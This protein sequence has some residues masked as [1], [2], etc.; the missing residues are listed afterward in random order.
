MRAARRT[1]SALLAFLLL[2]PVIALTS[3]T[4]D[5]HGLG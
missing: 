2:T 1:L 3:P 4:D 5:E